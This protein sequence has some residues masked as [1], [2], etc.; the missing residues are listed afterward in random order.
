MV[1][2]VEK[3]IRDSGLGINPVVDGPIIRCRSPN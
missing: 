3:A 2:K 1:G